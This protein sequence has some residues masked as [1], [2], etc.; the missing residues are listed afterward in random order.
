MRVVQVK[1]GAELWI[2]E[3]C[4]LAA[5][6]ALDNGHMSLLTKPDGSPFDSS[7]LSAWFADRYCNRLTGSCR[8]LCGGAVWGGSAHA[9]IRFHRR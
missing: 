8:V 7:G 5:E 6:L 3:H 9:F 4:D 1:T 2:P